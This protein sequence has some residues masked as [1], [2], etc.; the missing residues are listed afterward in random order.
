MKKT[1][2]PSSSALTQLERL[3]VGRLR[4]LLSGLR[5]V[6]IELVAKEDEARHDANAAR[7]ELKPHRAA[8]DEYD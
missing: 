3:L 5:R 7:E 1:L 4:G 8:K 2:Q 6:S